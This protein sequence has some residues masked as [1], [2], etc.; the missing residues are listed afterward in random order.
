[1]KKLLLLF[2]TATTIMSYGAEKTSIEISLRKN[3]DSVIFVAP[4]I[5]GITLGFTDTLYVTEGKKATL[6]LEINDLSS[7]YLQHGKTFCNVIV[8]PGKNYSV[9]FDYEADPIIQISDPV[10]MLRNK[11][12]QEKNFYKYEFVRD[13]KVT[14]LDTVGTKM[15]AN[16]D[17]LLTA[18]KKQFEKLEMSQAMRKFIELDLEL[19]WMGSM[20]KV[21]RA[22]F[23]DCSSNEKQMYNDYMKEWSQI[24]KDYP[25]TTQMIPSQYFKS[26]VEIAAT[27]KSATDG[28]VRDFK[29][30]QEY[31]DYL[32]NNVRL[33]KNQK[34]KQ[35]FWAQALFMEALN[36]K[37]FEK[38]LKKYINEFLTTYPNEG[39]KTTFIPFIKAI[40][41]FHAKV[42]SEFDK[43]VSFVENGD[44]IKTLQELLAKFKGKPVLVDFWF[45][46]CGPCVSNSKRFGKEMERFAEQNGITLLC[47]SIDEDIEQWHN[48]I[49]YYEIGGNHIKTCKS[50]H[51]DIYKAYSIYMFPHYMLVGSNG[52]ILINRLKDLSEGNDF[53]N[54]IHDALGKNNV[55][56][57]FAPL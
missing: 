53:Y 30:A 12:F 20:A 7:V 34:I 33:I 4:P 37:R 48:A 49:K 6:Q 18:D 23:S 41:L 14:P 26:Y 42:D 40:D 54:Q 27:L 38:I 51:E 47:I 36:N 19:Y 50:L 5:E 31:Y 44:S 35:A 11:V 46:T 13:Y 24:Y 1:M 15:R 16:F 29:T 21:I 39:F 32:F 45:S 57:I 55:S 9:C 43:N 17:S 25:L 56:F 2:I 52:E 22:N 10:Q 8:E 3:Q 28:K